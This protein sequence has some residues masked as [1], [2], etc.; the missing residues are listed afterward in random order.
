MR[1][2]NIL[3]RSPGQS[4][5]VCPAKPDGI[6]FDRV[7]KI[8]CADEI[9]GEK[10]GGIATIANNVLTKTRRICRG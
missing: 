8:F 6:S 7:R 5:A 9:D 3:Q 1:Y 4:K 10:N 2:F